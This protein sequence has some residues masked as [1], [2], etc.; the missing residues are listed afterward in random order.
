MIFSFEN[1]PFGA[2]K[3]I[4]NRKYIAAEPA[5][6]IINAQ[7]PLERFN[8][9]N[10]SNSTNRIYDHEPEH[11]R[12]SN[13]T[14]RIENPIPAK[15]VGIDQARQISRTGGK[16]QRHTNGMCRNVDDEID[17]IRADANH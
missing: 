13:Y 15:I 3:V 11:L 17:E 5:N 7:R 12:S 8:D 16:H 1:E 4:G 2:R 6:T 14:L 10:H 9:E